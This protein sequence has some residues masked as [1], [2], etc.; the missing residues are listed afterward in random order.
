MLISIDYFAEL[1]FKRDTAAF[2]L[3]FIEPIA[4][5]PTSTP[6]PAMVAPPTATTTPAPAVTPTPSV[7]TPPSTDR[8]LSTDTTACATTGPAT[9]AAVT[10]PASAGHEVAVPAPVAMKPFARSIFPE[11]AKTA[12]TDPCSETLVRVVS[13]FVFTSPP[14]VVFSGLLT[15]ETSC[16]SVRYTDCAR[17]GDSALMRTQ[18]TP[19]K[20]SSKWWITSVAALVCVCACVCVCVVLVVLVVLARSLGNYWSFSIRVN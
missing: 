3:D 6:A 16:C 10:T 2:Y 13:V 15:Q 5:A 17:C 20:Y 1:G 14:F 7:T 12:P 8:V 11:P 18:Q 9:R 19:S 4:S